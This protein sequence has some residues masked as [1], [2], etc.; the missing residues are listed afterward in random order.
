[1]TI[2]RAPS[3]EITGEAFSFV[4]AATN[5]NQTGADTDPSDLSALIG[6]NTA[7]DGLRIGRDFDNMTKLS[8]VFKGKVLEPFAI[9][10]EWD[11]DATAFGGK[12]DTDSRVC[13]E[14]SS[15]YPA[16][17]SGL[18]IHMQTNDRG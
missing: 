1:M 6:V 16:T 14:A 5:I 15:P 3:Y 2:N 12:F 8:S 18:V 11:Y 4:T 13:I 7:P 10:E 9:V 17:I